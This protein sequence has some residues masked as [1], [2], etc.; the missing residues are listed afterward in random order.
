MRFFLSWLLLLAVFSHQSLFGQFTTGL[1]LDDPG[2]QTLPRQ[3]LYGDGGKSENEAL[4]GVLKVDLRP[5][6]PRPRNQGAISSCVGWSSG[7][8]AL[9]IQH[10]IRNDW[11]NQ[12]DT[13]TRHA[14]SS[15]FV[16]NQIKINECSSGAYI[17]EALKF[18]AEK[19][20]V[21]AWDFDRDPS[22]CTVLPSLDQLN[23]AAGFKVKDYLTLFGDE[24]E[25]QVKIDKTKLSLVQ[26][27]PVVIGMEIRNNFQR[28]TSADTYWFPDAGDRQSLGGHAMCV[29]GFDEGK[30]A[31]EIMNSWGPYWGN[32]GF[33]WVKYSDYARFC[34][35]GA[36][37][38]L[39]DPP[40][41]LPEVQ[42][43]EFVLRYPASI[44]NGEVT[45]GNVKP[46]LSYGRYQ[47]NRAQG[48]RLQ[49]VASHLNA[50]S[51]L[52]VF[53]L[54]PE[55]NI[56]VHWP[57]DETLDQAFVGKHESATISTASVS[58]VL[59]T[60]QTTLVFN[61]TG[62]DQVVILYAN[63]PLTDLNAQLVRIKSLY[64]SDLMA[65]LKTVFATRLA[66][67]AQLTYDPARCAFT[68]KVPSKL[69]V[70]ILI[71]VNVT[72]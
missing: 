50:G 41:A 16:Y 15:L 23:E 8:A 19:G 57:R 20:D 42:H 18:L 47:I 4:K 49:I 10:A 60:P 3:S 65:T 27:K 70:P 69:I 9:S 64:R 25:P 56:K 21:R 24:S 46:T 53:S 28:M 17:S 36:Q 12:T 6:C 2:Y 33:I 52:Y 5:Y 55:K 22:N 44:T 68:S 13:I 54:D 38:T 37:F 66:P 29:V 72:P 71:E 35:F 11:K 45:F 26:N 7:Y 34:R 48:D 14:F 61:Q 39:A 1:E 43:G 40:K 62:K 63:S 58:L 51:Y 32:G 30:E 59:P 67:A 31:F